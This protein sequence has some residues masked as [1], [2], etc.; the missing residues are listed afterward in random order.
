MNFGEAQTFSPL[1]SPFLSLNEYAHPDLSKL[2]FFNKLS[3]G[4]WN[5]YLLTHFFA[6]SFL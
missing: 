1:Q 3:K 4:N 5:I 6:Y 2:I